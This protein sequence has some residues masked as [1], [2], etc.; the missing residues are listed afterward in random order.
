ME[1]VREAAKLAK[2]EEEERA[3][4]ENA[5]IEKARMELLARESNSAAGAAKVRRIKMGVLS[6]DHVLLL[7]VDV[8]GTD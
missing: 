8:Y 1:G 7:V 4:A 3:A 6:V 2:Q 5:E